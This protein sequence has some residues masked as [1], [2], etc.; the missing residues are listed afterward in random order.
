MDI[1]EST[2]EDVQALSKMNQ[3]LIEDE[4]ED[5][6]LSLPYLEARMSDYLKSGYRAFFFLQDDKNVGYALCNTSQSPMYL[7]QFFIN[8][9]ERRKGYGTEA[10]HLLLSHLDIQEIDIDVYSWNESGISFWKSLGFNKRR[11]S[12]VFKR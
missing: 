7:R 5:V 1:K 10:F 6:N 3:H 2:M 12:M 8:R 4:E 11:L 9:D